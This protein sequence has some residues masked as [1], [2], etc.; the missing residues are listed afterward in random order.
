MLDRK[1]K[2]QNTMALKAEQRR[3]WYERNGNRPFPSRLV[4]RRGE[5][6]ANFPA[7]INRHTG[8]PHEH[9]RAIARALRQ[10]GP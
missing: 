7:S 10:E 3:R 9:R 2:H 1:L 6:V 4:R 5:Y 8:E